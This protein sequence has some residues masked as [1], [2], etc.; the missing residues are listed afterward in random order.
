MKKT[1]YGKRLFLV[2]LV[3][4]MLSII[5]NVVLT[6]YTDNYVIAQLF[7]LIFQ[8]GML[9]C[10]IYICRK[11]NLKI[12]RCIENVF[13]HSINTIKA[14]I[15]FVLLLLNENVFLEYNVLGFHVIRALSTIILIVGLIRYKNQE[16]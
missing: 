10:V 16:N 5:S 4:A 9:F 12:I 8:C 15:M 1:C 13:I 6:A 14:I 11:N 7:V 2:L 3:F